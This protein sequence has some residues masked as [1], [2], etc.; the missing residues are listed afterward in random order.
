[1]NDSLILLLVLVGVYLHDCSLWL[2]R[3]TVAFIA[4]GFRRWRPVRPHPLL[5]GA[6]KGLLPSFR[7]PPLTPVYLSYPW[8]IVASP[9]HVSAIPPT[10]VQAT[11]PSLGWQ[12]VLN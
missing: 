10:A 7:L 3:D 9:T 12:V 11:A 2:D 4:T 6:A 1:M 5:S 8:R